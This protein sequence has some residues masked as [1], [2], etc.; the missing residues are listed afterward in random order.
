MSSPDGILV[1]SLDS[2]D[3][4]TTN[5]P[6]SAITLQG[7]HLS[8]VVAQVK[9]SFEGKLNKDGTEIAGK[10]TEG[11]QLPLKLQRLSSSAMVKTPRPVGGDWIGNI[12][13]KN[14]NLVLLLHLDTYTQTLL[15]A[16]LERPGQSATATKASDVSFN[17]DQ[18][19]FKVEDMHA[20]YSGTLSADGSQ[21]EG[22]WTEDKV[23]TPLVW[24]RAVDTVTP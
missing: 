23:K 17:Q 20:S 15:A 10:W 5:I 22:L 3:Q 16:T 24:K 19:R 4:D 21:I 8:F 18:L 6:V 12:G 14:G 9:G 7:S 1:A 2:L 11:G 13:A